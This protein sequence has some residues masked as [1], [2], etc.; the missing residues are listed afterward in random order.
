M[1]ICGT[2]TTPC[3]PRPASQGDP[4]PA[5]T[6]KTPHKPE[7]ARTDGK[8][9]PLGHQKSA[10]GGEKRAQIGKTPPLVAK[11]SPSTEKNAHKPQKARPQ[12]QKTRP[13]REK[14][15]TNGRMHPLS[16]KM[17]ARTK[18]CDFSRLRT[19]VREIADRS[20]SCER[21]FRRSRRVC[22]M[23]WHPANRKNGSID[24]NPCMRRK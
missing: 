22:P 19:S 24:P 18:P 17:S 9:R 8:K 10:L 5:R 7:K 4:N 23:R 1:L 11:S 16:R 21:A 12:R 6:G 15:R 3:R 13:R 20:G 14:A 2:Q